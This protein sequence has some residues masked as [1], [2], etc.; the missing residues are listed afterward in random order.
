MAFFSSIW[1]ETRAMQ[2]MMISFFMMILLVERRF[3]S[4]SFKDFL[5]IAICPYSSLQTL[6]GQCLLKV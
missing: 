6:Q 3:M 1:Q 2:A 5:K 4:E